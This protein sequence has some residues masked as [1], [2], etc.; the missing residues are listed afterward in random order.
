MSEKTT[1]YLVRHGETEWNVQHRFQGHQDSALT[2]RG[3]HQA[4]RLAES[5]KEIDI[6]YIY[7]S[8][9]TRATR[10][11]KIIKG[12]RNVPVNTCGDLREIG[13]GVWEGRLQEEI[14]V[15]DSDAF[16]MFWEDPGEFKVQGAE[17]FQEVQKRAIQQLQCIINDHKGCSILIV[18]HTAVVKLIMAH[19]DK[20]SMNEL[21]NPPFIQPA[22]VCKVE[23]VDNQA[24]IISHGDIAHYIEV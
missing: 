5:L 11:A 2:K 21:W 17:T 4:E 7:T 1:I 16:R 14:K 3:I 9:S 10:T 24:Y 19:F 18:T 6:H 13:L 12:G 23:I 20:R 8:S 15:N 22:S